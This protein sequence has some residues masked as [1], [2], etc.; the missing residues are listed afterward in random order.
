[1]AQFRVLVAFGVLF[2]ALRANGTGT[3]D[4]ATVDVLGFVHFPTL[5]GWAQLSLRRPQE[6]GSGSAAAS[7]LWR[8]QQPSSLST[9]ALD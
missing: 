2:T 1:M 5:W 9:K 7:C 4:T 6:A 8:Q 3:T